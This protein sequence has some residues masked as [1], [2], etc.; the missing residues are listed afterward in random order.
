MAVHPYLS[1]LFQLPEVD[2]IVCND[3]KLYIYTQNNITKV[4]IRVKNSLL[5]LYPF[6]YYKSLRV[7]RLR[8]SVNIVNIVNC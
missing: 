3:R 4:E 7:D 8:H 6:D 1:W 5:V 2:P